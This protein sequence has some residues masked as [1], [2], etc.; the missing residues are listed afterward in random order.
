MTGG[1]REAASHYCP[2]I[3]LYDSADP[4][5][6]E[7]QVL[8]MKFAGI[9]GV[10]VDWY[11][12]DDFL[13]FGVNHRNTVRLIEAVNRAGLTYAIVY[14]D[15]AVQKL[16]AANRLPQADAVAHGAVL[17]QWMQAHWF[18]TPAYL[19]QDGRPVL[20]VFGGPG[21]YQGDQWTQIFANLPRPPALYTETIRRP[22]AVGGFDWP[23]PAGGTGKSLQEVDGFYRR[24]AEWPHYIPAAFPGFRDI[25]EQAGVQKSWGT[26]EDRAGKTYEETLGRALKSGAAVTQIATWNDWGE[27]TQ[28]EPSVENGY[29]DLET[30]QRLRR[31]YLEPKFR[32]TAEDLRLPV[33]LYNLR[34][35]AGKDPG[36]ARKLD[37]IARLLF[38]GDPKK[39]RRL[40]TGVGQ[41][42]GQRAAPQP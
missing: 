11:G 37:E 18:S 14:E 35:K 29:R 7:C 21:Y 1:R 3:G 34:K 31:K 26:I 15:S 40:M 23:Q 20:L 17:L 19:Q 8:L 32:Y 13:D 33:A 2:L 38:A 22:P 10:L 39:A 24:A 28:I 4:D 6:L 9:S 5:T 12:M 25:Y 16:I 30:T 36:S 42:L 27:G 41:Y